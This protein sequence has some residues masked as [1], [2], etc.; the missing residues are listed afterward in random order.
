MSGTYSDSN[1][2]R[3]HEEATC[4]ELLQ[5]R[6]A[7]LHE[8]MDKYSDTPRTDEANKQY[9]VDVYDNPKGFGV[10]EPVHASFARELERENNEL[11]KQ[12]NGLR[13]GLPTHAEVD[14]LLEDKKR[15]DWLLEDCELQYWAKELTIL[16]PATRE[17]IDKAMEES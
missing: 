14:V 16:P 2:H 10:A 6:Q 4:K 9:Q 5:V 3:M 11:R 8:K 15:L 1:R 13:T 17:E 12:N 7:D